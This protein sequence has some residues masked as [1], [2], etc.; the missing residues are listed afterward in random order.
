MHL[1]N[2][3]TQQQQQKQNVMHRYIQSA[4]TT[5]PRNEQTTTEWVYHSSHSTSKYVV[6]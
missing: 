3:R 4:T 5:W 1:L 2:Q 6:V